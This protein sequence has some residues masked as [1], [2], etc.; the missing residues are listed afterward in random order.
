MNE[1][2]ENIGTRRLHTV[3][4]RSMED[5]SYDASEKQGEVYTNDAESENQHLETLLD[6]QDLSQF[7]L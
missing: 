3:L 7:I 4:E 5:I 1:K 2:T 6:H